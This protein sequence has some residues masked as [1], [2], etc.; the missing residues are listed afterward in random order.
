MIIKILEEKMI[1]F[2]GEGRLHGVTVD[3]FEFS[4]LFKQRSIASTWSKFAEKSLVPVLNY[5][6]KLTTDK[7]G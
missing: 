7:L 3:R 1:N 5:E 6:N 4:C 2:Q